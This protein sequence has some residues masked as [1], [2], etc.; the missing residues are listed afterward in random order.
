MSQ[1]WF[2]TGSSRG[3]GREFATAALERG[4]HVAATARD[5]EALADLV[6][7]FGDAVL[8]LSLDVSDR[9]SVGSVVAR[10]REHFGRLD[11]VVNNAGYGLFGAVEEVTE[12][13]VRD[14]FE[15]NVF[16]ALWVTQAVLPILREQ[17]SG[18]IIQ[19]SSVGGVLVVPYT[20]IYN[21][22]KWA[23]EAFSEALHH[24]VAPFGVSVTLIEPGAFATEWGTSSKVIA[25]QMPAYDSLRVARAARSAAMNVGDPGAAGQALLSIVDAPNPPLRVLFGTDALAW[26]RDTYP[27]RLAE[28]ADW[29]HVAVAA[30]GA[31]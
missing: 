3:L 4:D 20:G 29:E 19:V 8:P 22:S 18:H 17:G 21:A 27:K 10:A 7:R 5:A 12:E 30:Q 1:V 2:I 26:V 15:T 13:L 14:Q 23:L 25:P 28:W 11:V 6:A 31:P 24:E 16:G 9:D